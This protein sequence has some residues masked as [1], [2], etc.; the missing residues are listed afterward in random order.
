MVTSSSFAR[1][2][3]PTE[4]APWGSKSTSRTRRPS[5]ARAAPRLIVVVV[6]PTP[7]FWLHMAMMRAGPWEVQ[8]LGVGKSGM[9]RPV[10]PIGLLQRAPCPAGV[11]GSLPLGFVRLVWSA[12]CWSCATSER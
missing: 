3:R 10:G 9:G 4:A 1:T 6:L 2:P 5:S 11:A 12:G 8:G 7:P